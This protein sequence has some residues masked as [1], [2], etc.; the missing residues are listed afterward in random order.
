MSK[1]PPLTEQEK[2]DLVA[3]LDGELTGAAARALEARLNLDPAARAEAEVLRRTWDLL[4][5]LPCPEPSPSFTSRTLSRLGKIPSRAVRKPVRWKLV[6]AGAG[7]AAGLLLAAL[8]G[9]SAYHYLAPRKPGEAELVRDLRLIENKRFYDLV[10]DL[11][12]LKDLDHPDLFGD[13]AP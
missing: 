8:A 7:W 13:E 2:A 3:Y 12:F 6:L 4:D 9:R 10:G 1:P 5:Y 11:D